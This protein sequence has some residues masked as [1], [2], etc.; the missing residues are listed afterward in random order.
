MANWDL[1]PLGLGEILD[2]TFSLYRQNFLLFMGIT[3]VPH[4]LIL[5]MKLYQT[6]TGPVVPL[7]PGRHPIGQMHAPAPNPFAGLYVGGL[8]F[9]TLVGVLVYFFTYILTQGATVS[10]VSELYLGRT[11]T[12]GGSLRRVGGHFFNLCVVTF[13]SW[14]GIGIALLFL[15][16]P[17]IYVG[18]RL[19]V[20]VPAAFL[21]D[22]GPSALERSV[23]LTE[24]SAGRA[25]VI[26]ILYIAV[27]YAASSLF[28]FPFIFMVAFLSKDPGILRTWMAIMQVGGFIAGVLVGPVLTIATT[29]FYYDLRVRKEAFDLQL[30]MHPSG[31][32]PSGTPGVPTMLS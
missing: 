12:I 25:F 14:V 4:L 2:R 32:I 17:G 30:M 27:S 13:L 7:F 16:I 20:C 31:V 21:E 5:A 1:R 22:L 24:G 29:V 8:I 11:A 6:L 9:G 23:R 18:C 10:A 26:Y 19:M 3:A 28:A 15:V